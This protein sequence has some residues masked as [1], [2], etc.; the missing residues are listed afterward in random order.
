MSQRFSDSN[1]GGEKEEN[2]QT[3]RGEKKIGGSIKIGE[4]GNLSLS[5]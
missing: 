2:Y 3:F 1:Y 5:T 4:R